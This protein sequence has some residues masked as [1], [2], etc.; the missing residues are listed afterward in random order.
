MVLITNV[1]DGQ[2]KTPK[3]AAIYNQTLAPGEQIKL[4]AELVDS[5]VRTLEKAGIISIGTPPAWWAGRKKGKRLSN[6]EI[7][8]RVA[9]TPEKPTVSAPEPVKREKQRIHVSP[10]EPVSEE[11]SPETESSGDSLQFGNRKK[12]G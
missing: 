9:P 10:S 4:P 12:K 7:L 5:K 1:T 6:E 11:T 2:G 3:E 8:R